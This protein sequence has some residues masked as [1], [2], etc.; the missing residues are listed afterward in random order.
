MSKPTRMTPMLEQ[1]MSIKRKH[2]DKLVLFRMGDFY[3]TFFDDAV[4]VSKLLGIQLTSRNHGKD[5]K[6]PL[7]GIPYHALKGYADKLTK[8]GRSFVIVEQT[9]DP[10]QANG[11]V[12]RGVTEIVT[13]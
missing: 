11:I 3:E 7:A 13:P 9:E 5:D 10:K 8:A 12:R 1:F 6:V 2:Q 4:E